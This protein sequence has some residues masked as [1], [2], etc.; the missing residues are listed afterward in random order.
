MKVT[1]FEDPSDTTMHHFLT[2]TGFDLKIAPTGASW[3]HTFDLWAT[4]S[5]WDGVDPFVQG[6]TEKISITVCNTLTS[7]Q[8]KTGTEVAATSYQIGASQK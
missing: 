3:T 6:A 5:F 2:W 1:I 8:V 4:P 7:I